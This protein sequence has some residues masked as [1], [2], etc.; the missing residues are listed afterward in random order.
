[1]LRIVLTTLLTPVAI[2]SGLL[3]LLGVFAQAMSDAP[4]DDTGASVA[5]RALFLFVACIGAIF[6]LNWG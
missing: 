3:A 4:C 5:R 2:G 1:M 6:A